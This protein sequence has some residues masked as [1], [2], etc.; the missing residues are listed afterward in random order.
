VWG[1][2]W[3]VPDQEVDQRKREEWLWKKTARHIN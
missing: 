1:V 3:R 2:R